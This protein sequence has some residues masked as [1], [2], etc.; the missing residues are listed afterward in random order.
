MT[1]QNELLIAGLFRRENADWIRL[2][3][4][5]VHAAEQDKSIDLIFFGDSI[6]ESF[7]ETRL[8]VPLDT[9]IGGKEV[10]DRGFADFGSKYAF[11][12]AGMQTLKCCTTLK[13]S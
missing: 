2:H 11:G 10:F 1:L 6:A 13:N 12:I 9:L 5:Y 4:A 7:R 8:G 3:E